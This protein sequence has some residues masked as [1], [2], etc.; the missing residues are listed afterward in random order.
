ME[1]KVISSPKFTL[2]LRD[3]LRGAILAVATPVL[4]IVQQTIETGVLKFNWPQI[5]TVALGAFLAYIGKNFLFE[6]A[7]V[8]TTTTN[9][10]VEKV[11]NKINQSI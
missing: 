9:E 11:E 3:F 5:G 8:I 4:V 6:P 1:T 2:Q 10:A 7:K